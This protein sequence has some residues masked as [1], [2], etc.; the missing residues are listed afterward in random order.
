MTDFES[1][2]QRFPRPRRSRATSPSSWTATAAGRRS[3][4]S[5]ASAGIAR[6][7]R[8]CARS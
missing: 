3:A 8:R 7:S 1:S 2:T 6:A 4:S 5:R